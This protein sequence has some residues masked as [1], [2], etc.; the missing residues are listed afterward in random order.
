MRYQCYCC[1]EEVK[2]TLK[3]V[4]ISYQRIKSPTASKKEIE[5]TIREETHELECN[6][7][8]DFFSKKIVMPVVYIR[9]V[10]K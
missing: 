8:N 5:K 10:Q 2:L 9:K 7:E 1:N 4:F 6:S 3:D